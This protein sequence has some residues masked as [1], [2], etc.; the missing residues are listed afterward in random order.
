MSPSG[1]VGLMFDILRCAT[2]LNGTQVPVGPARI[3]KRGNTANSVLER[4]RAKKDCGL[5]RGTD[6]RYVWKV[7]AKTPEDAVRRGIG[8]RNKFEDN[9]E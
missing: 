2:L 3:R 9:L 6:V 1:S 7:R 5:D 8:Q 4:P